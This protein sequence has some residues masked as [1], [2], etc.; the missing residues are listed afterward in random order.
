MDGTVRETKSG[1]TFI[2]SPEDQQLIAGVK[3]AIAKYKKKGWL[4]IGVTNQKGVSLGYKSLEDCIKEQRIT[5]EL[6][7]E[8][9]AIYLCPDEG[10]NLV[11]VT[12]KDSNTIN[13]YN[14]I[15]SEEIDF[16][17]FR[18]PDIGIIEYIKKELNEDIKETLFVGDMESDRE[19]AEKAGIP[20]IEAEEWR[21]KIWI[22]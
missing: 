22:V 5:L 11:W 4:M 16:S 14:N 8:I 10:E 3:E 9:K 18:K 15:Y 12:R 1:K 20:F 21:E 2:N 7:P 17:S 13:R 6:V 19:C